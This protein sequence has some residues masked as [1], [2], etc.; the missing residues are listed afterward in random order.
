MII[1]AAPLGEFAGIDLSDFSGIKAFATDDEAPTNGTCGESL[2]W[3]FDKETGTLTISG[4]GEMYDYDYYNP[5]PWADFSESI[6]AV[7]VEEG[8]T[9]IGDSSFEYYEN[10]RNVIIT[11]SVQKIGEYSFHDCISLESI[12]LPTKAEYGRYMMGSGWDRASASE[13]SLT[14][15]NITLKWNKSDQTT[16]VNIDETTDIDT[17]NNIYTDLFDFCGYI[18]KINLVEDNT[19]FKLIDG[20][21][22]NSEVT[23]L[24]LFPGASDMETYV[25]PN[26]VSFNLEYYCSIPAGKNL[27]DITFGKNY[28]TSYFDTLFSAEDFAQKYES[29]TS[30]NEK[31][32][33]IEYYL[34]YELN[35]PFYLAIHMNNVEKLSV[36]E[37]NKYLKAENGILMCKY[38]G[39]DLYIRQYEKHIEDH[40][41]DGNDIVL[42]TATI[43]FN[44]EVDKLT[45]SDEFIKNAIS[46]E[47]YYY[48]LY[49]QNSYI[50][51]DATEEQMDRITLSSV[52][53]PFVSG[54]KAKEYIIPESNDTFKSV[55]GMILSKDEKI[56]FAF[57]MGTD[58]E[59]YEIPEIDYID[60]HA[61]SIV[62]EG[63]VVHNDNV[64]VHIPECI[65]DGTTKAFRS[66]SFNMSAVVDRHGGIVLM[67]LLKTVKGVCIKK[68]PNVYTVYGEEYSPEGLAQ[69]IEQSNMQLQ[70]IR[71][72][73]AE[74]FENGEMTQF[75][76]DEYALMYLGGY[77]E[78]TLPVVC[79]GKHNIIKEF[80]INEIENTEVKFGETLT[81]TANP[82]ETGLPD[83]CKVEWTIDGTGAEITV[84]EDTLSCTFKCVDSGEVTVTAKVVDAEG[85]TITD[86]YG[87]DAVASQ[88]LTM[89]ASF[90]VRVEAFFKYLWNLILDLFR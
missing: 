83:G 70:Y 73:F 79:G 59:F 85:N 84:S 57:P 13:I 60:L 38:D 50:L 45:L 54:Y 78:L 35:D 69:I 56:L 1:S 49:Q 53:L 87:K 22:Y 47:K 77:K 2:T 89:N 80:S 71:E 26:T 8:V 32:R 62:G 25:M 4:E 31:R 43:F 10:L 30:T 39:Y 18:E 12:K 15:K 37:G 36:A 76:Y 86:E 68:E 58:R 6:I 19:D 17:F 88:T 23:T 90:F 63:G 34:S 48:S 81:L 44:Q 24:L 20:V 42:G 41:V 14:N 28:L 74:R 64:T 16:I 5:A 67:E 51:K 82:G 29:A 75:E 66:P 46:Y 21:L 72:E 52:I 7:V 40:T 33:L 3:N 11:D 27:K 65:L 55:N 9:S 61:F